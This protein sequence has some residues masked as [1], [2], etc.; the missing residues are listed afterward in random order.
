MEIRAPSEIL[1]SKI[2]SRISQTNSH[3][4]DMNWTPTHVPADSKDVKDPTIDGWISV[5]LA[6]KRSLWLNSGKNRHPEI[7]STLPMEAIKN[8]AA[9]ID[10]LA[11]LDKN[12]LN[13]QDLKDRIIK[14]MGE[15]QVNMA[16]SEPPAPVKTVTPPAST[17]S[18]IP[19]YALP[20]P[21]SL[22]LP[23]NPM[24][25][26]PK[27]NLPPPVS[28]GYQQL[29]QAQQQQQHQAQPP[30]QIPVSYPPPIR[31]LPSE[32]ILLMQPPVPTQQPD[33]RRS[34]QDPRDPRKVP[35]EK[36]YKPQYYDEDETILLIPLMRQIKTLKDPRKSKWN[37][38]EHD[39]KIM[40]LTNW[41]GKI[42]DF[43]LESLTMRERVQNHVN[44]A[45][46]LRYQKE[47]KERERLLKHEQDKIK[48][49]EE[50]EF[51]QLQ[52]EK[53]DRYNRKRGASS[54]ADHADPFSTGLSPDSRKRQASSEPARPA[55]NGYDHKKA[56]QDMHQILSEAS[57]KKR[58]RIADIDEKISNKI[59]EN[60]GYSLADINLPD[61]P[62]MPSM[63][64][65][66]DPRKR[67]NPASVVDPRKQQSQIS[68][69]DPRSRASDPRNRNSTQNSNL[70][71]ELPSVS[72]NMMNGFSPSPSGGPGPAGNVYLNRKHK[73]LSSSTNH[74]SV[75][76]ASTSPN[77]PKI[78]KKMSLAD[79]LT[80]KSEAD[81]KSQESNVSSD[82]EE[83][84]KS[85]SRNMPSFNFRP[86]GS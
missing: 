43:Y 10:I 56:V 73:N 20:D 17:I 33:L 7:I 21:S 51:D 37:S 38:P 39:N 75:S 64:K 45:K 82:E 26:L 30:S 1:K 24:M 79:Y 29:H 25:D 22:P 27:P 85:S 81:E 55:H 68:S 72:T 86:F 12:G 19:A 67:A 15:A 63:E 35:A 61:L 16:N 6:D 62:K 60:T 58:I 28:L 52:K 5:W 13:I 83:T 46:V 66:R 8:P 69:R 48:A 49:R 71:G 18:A 42:P 47:Q 84:K 57:S 78:K 76:A 14:L 23:P 59:P 74:T 41:C 31:G 40:D 53:Y 34:A 32:A 50:R 77:A 44:K 4:V 2:V 65:T 36:P 70:D 11:N 3:H 54:V 80:V 9:M